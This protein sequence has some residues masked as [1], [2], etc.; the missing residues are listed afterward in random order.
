VVLEQEIVRRWP[1]LRFEEL[2]ARNAKQLDAEAQR[3]FQI[4]QRWEGIAGKA[5]PGRKTCVLENA[6]AEL[7][8][9]VGADSEGAGGDTMRFK[10]DRALDG[11]LADRDAPAHNEV[12][13]HGLQRADG[14]IAA[15]ATRLHRF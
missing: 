11:I 12:D 13:E 8:G 5:N 9:N 14:I 6:N 10:K 15:V 1:T 4:R 3:R 7:V 2:A